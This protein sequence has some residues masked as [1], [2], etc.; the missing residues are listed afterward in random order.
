MN[1]IGNELILCSQSYDDTV[2][3]RKFGNT[4]MHRCTIAMDTFN[5]KNFTTYFYQIYLKTNETNFEIIPVKIE[6]DENTRQKN[7]VKR[8]FLAYQYSYNQD[9]GYLFAKEITFEVK[10][11]NDNPQSHSFMNIPVL[12]ITYEHQDELRGT[13]EFSFISNYYMDISFIMKWITG[14]F[15][16][17]FIIVFIIVA[18]RMYVWCILNPSNLT[19]ETYPCYFLIHLF[20]KIFKY[21]GIIMFFFTWGITAYWYIFFKCQYRPFVF[22]PDY[23]EKYKEHLR[24]FDILWGLACGSYGLYMMFRIYQQINCD[25]FFIDWE[26]EKDILETV[27]GK[28]SNKP[29]KSPWRSIHIVN[30]FN[31]LQKSRTISINFCFILFIMLYYS[32]KIEWHD[33]THLVP[34]V[35][36]AKNS[37]PHRL[38]RHFLGTFVLFIA[39]VAQYVLRRII[40]PWMPTNTTEFLDLC[41]V[42]NVS[43]LILQDSL[44][45]YYIH[46]QSPLGKADTTLQELIRFLEEE[47]KGKIKGRGITDDKNDNLQTYEIYLSYTMR[48]IYDGLYFFP[49]LQEIDK[50][51]QY[52]RIQNQAK[53]LNIFKYIPES[54]HTGNIYEINKFMNNHLKEKIEQV[55]MQSKLLV[56]EK[57]LCERFFEFP[58]SIDLTSRTVKELVFY[59]DPGK[60]FEDVLFIGMELEWLIFV[61]YIWEMWAL[62]LEKYQRSTPIAIFMTYIMERMFFKV[63]VF[64]GEKNVAKKAVVDNRFL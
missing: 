25:I 39:G 42:A 57:S 41:S 56:R 46:G 17:F 26:H 14:L 63:R 38:L 3:F 18:A 43:V 50:G 33:Y 47:G 58:P 49:T 22:F 62:A 45:G 5:Q 61:I 31:L 60:N 34:N 29:Y 4:I 27:M 52:D 44:R 55:T 40:Q 51:N 9:G 48:Q 21:F 53:F 20:S 15:S 16:A 12:K 30:Q 64:F 36:F 28:T 54:L 24:K 59:K 11:Q 23:F 37:P 19:K 8:F 1:K 2:D 13:Q 32:N 35:S 10:L 6:N 7:I